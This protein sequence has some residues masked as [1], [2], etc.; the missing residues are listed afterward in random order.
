[1]ISGSVVIFAAILSKLFLDRQLNRLHYAGCGR[2][3]QTDLPDITICKCSQP[4]GSNRPMTICEVEHALT[5]KPMAGMTA[6]DCSN[7]SIP[8]APM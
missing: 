1:M 8:R 5:G 7:T 3:S 2:L 6:P 4:T